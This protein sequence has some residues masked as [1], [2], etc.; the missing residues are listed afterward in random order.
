MGPQRESPGAEA[1][2]VSRCSPGCAS[3]TTALSLALS[4]HAP[5]NSS[6]VFLLAFLQKEMAL[7]TCLREI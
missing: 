5:L 3:A 7:V 2:V 1:P 4:L 6:L